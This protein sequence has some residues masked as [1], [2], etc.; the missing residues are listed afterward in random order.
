MSKPR[1]PRL[2]LFASAAV[3]AAGSCAHAATAPA[4][5]DAS[6]TPGTVAEV[7]V[8]AHRQQFRGDVP[9]QELPQNVSVVSAK[10]LNNANVTTLD[11]ALELVSGVQH[12]NNFGGL[13]N[14]FAIRG[15][16]GDPNLPSGYLINGFSSG[17]GFA[18]PRDTSDVERIEVLKGPS[19]ALFGRGEPGGTVNI[20][21]KKPLF[22]PQGYVSVA[23][24]SYNTWREEGDYTRGIIGDTLAGR[25]NGAYEEGDGFRDHGHYK[26]WVVTPSLLLDI[27]PA[28]T[29]T[30]ELSASH[31]EVPFDRG[32]LAVNGQLGVIPVSRFLGEPGDGPIKTDGLSHQLQFN[33]QF[34]S[35]W[36]LLLGADYLATQLKGFS[37]EAELVHPRQLLYFDGQDLSRERRYRDWSTH[38]AIVRAELDGRVQTGPFTH[39]LLFGV[40]DEKLDIHQ[41]QERFRPPPVTPGM[42]LAAANAINIFDPV[43][44]NLPPV[45]AFWDFFETQR[46]WGAYFQDQIDL[47][48][49]LKFRMG[50]RYDHFRQRILNRFTGGVTGQDV[51]ATDP[52]F[53]LVYEPSK[54]VSFYVAYGEGFR[55]NSGQDVNNVPFQPERTKSYEVGAKFHTMSELLEG[56]I[57]IYKMDKTGI[58]TSD[59]INAGYSMAIGKAESKGVEIDLD[60]VLPGRLQYW[61]SYAY[62]DAKMSNSILDPDFA[63]PVPAGAPLMGIPKHSGNVTVFREFHLANDR[64]FTLG[65]SVYYVSKR[66]GETGTNFFLPGYTLVK[67]FAA[68]DP[69]EHVKLSLEVNNLFDKVYYPASY[70]RLWILPG[71]PRE[72]TAKVTYRF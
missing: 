7:V 72:I 55:P 15:F 54:L 35:D 45:G 29:I 10:L 42:T 17:R 28:T 39:H 36:T 14:A 16:V 63:L 51:T 47:T 62:T 40:D 34:N 65:G 8:L 3:L 44:G 1:A 13:W 2:A 61:A 23:G 49:Q 70:S 33:H 21:T 59:P 52:Q 18:G 57:A 58:I 41:I 68:F 4:N 64:S 43:Y 69:T 19:S 50:A 26:K 11:S 37:T 31:Q 24:G 25:I 38:D 66:L 12:Q 22:N 9:I 27:D 5:H 56:T 48:S 71:T 6:A 46:A 67:A 32:V 30:Y 53:G 60:G 20:I